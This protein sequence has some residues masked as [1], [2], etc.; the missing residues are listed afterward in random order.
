MHAPPICSKFGK[1]TGV[2]I[3]P[4][5][6]EQNY[7]ASGWLGILTAGMLWTPLYDHAS[8]S[9]NVAALV[10]QI[11]KVVPTVGRVQDCALVDDDGGEDQLFTM[12]EMRAELE[13]LRKE[14]SAAPSRPQAGK[15]ADGPCDLPA[16]VPETPARMMVSDAMHVLVETVISPD[17]KLRVGFHGMCVDVPRRL[18]GLCGAVVSTALRLTRWY[19]AGEASG[20]Q[21]QAPGCVAM[22]SFVSILTA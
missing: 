8:F 16:V 4:V 1:Q 18:C 14:Y 15:A 20:R 2:P 9:D 12:D 17:S 21:R 19:F 22:I 10:R 13:R 7:K 5:L 6:M 11:Q 3:V